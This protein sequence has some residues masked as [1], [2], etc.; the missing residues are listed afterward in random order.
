MIPFK[1]STKK[2]TYVA[3]ATGV[4]FTVLAWFVFIGMTESADKAILFFLEGARF[5]FLN[6][7]FLILTYLGSVTFVSIATVCFTSI[8]FIK[9]KFDDVSLLLGTALGSSAFVFL[10]KNLIGRI[11][12]ADVLAVYSETSFSFPSGHTAIAVVFYG[13]VAY[14]LAQKFTNTKIRANV[15]FGWI[16]F[17][18]MIGF[19][20]MY[21]GVHYASDVLGGYLIGFLCLSIGIILFEK[22]SN[23]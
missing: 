15:L 7:L 19:S 9:K 2:L 17:M 11:R 4:F 18:A 14:I 5:P 8:L 21:L 6:E 16:F 22:Y 10:L 1:V 23:K 3:F 13:S 12:P 20:R